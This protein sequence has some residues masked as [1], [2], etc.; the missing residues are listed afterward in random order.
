MMCYYT[1][2]MYICKRLRK[3]KLRQEMI[4]N[5]EGKTEG[6]M[7]NIAICDD[8]NNFIKYI[9]KMLFHSGLEREEVLIYEYNSGEELVRSLDNCER[10][11]LLILDMQ[12]GRLNGH[13]T[14][15]YF[16]K[17]FPSS[18]IVFCSGVCLPTV[19]TFETTPFRYLLKEYTDQ[20]MV[21]EL[22]AVIQEMKKKIIEPHVIGTWR[23]NMVKLRLEEILYISIARRGSNI[24]VNPQITRYEMDNYML[25]KKKV[26]ELYHILKSYGFEYAHNSYIVNLDYIKRMN[27]LELEL[28]DGTILSIAR[29][30]EKNLR[31]AF[32]RY[33][34]QKY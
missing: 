13:E 23:N 11:D 12:M 6:I 10:I 21:C 17:Q 19:E 18:V 29:S 32:A 28:T 9:K 14:A 1:A 4:V 5:N 2:T 31:M 3:Y 34:A 24:Y 20:K 27:S 15:K 22:K 8:D 33:K 7:Y 26:S 30:K 16:R 25:S